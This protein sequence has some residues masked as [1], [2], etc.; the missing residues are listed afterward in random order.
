MLNCSPENSHR[1]LTGE[2]VDILVRSNKKVKQD[3]LSSNQ[4]GS[5][6]DVMNVDEKSN[7][8]DQEGHGGGIPVV[9]IKDTPTVSQIPQ[10]GSYRDS[11]MKFGT[12]GE[13]ANHST[14][15]EDEI[16]DFD[17]LFD[18]LEDD[19]LVEG[20]EDDPPNPTIFTT[21]E[22]I[23]EWAQPWRGSLIVKL[24]GK[25]G[26]GSSSQPSS[27]MVKDINQGST[28][29]GKEN[30]K[31]GSRFEIPESLDMETEA[32][33]EQEVNKSIKARA[34]SNDKQS[35]KSQVNNGLRSKRVHGGVKAVLGI[36]VKPNKVVKEDGR[37]STKTKAIIIN[38]VSNK[39][40]QIKDNT[41]SKEGQLH[42]SSQEIQNVKT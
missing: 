14:G 41:I 20:Q 15:T 32:T 21:K 26:K 13:T 29:K 18:E 24:M 19:T 22:E 38:E 4:P 8:N 35:S 12:Q 17:D 9:V 16:D 40:A 37:K 28:T 11:L 31:S 6:K 10:T 33:R 25:K 5:M 1:E 27:S 34:M 7:Q 23:R 3:E 2:E 42:N 30:E 36:K 39:K